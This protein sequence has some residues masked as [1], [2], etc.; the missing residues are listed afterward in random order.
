MGCLKQNFYLFENFKA[1]FL[2]VLFSYILKH[3]ATLIK[4]LLFKRSLW[5]L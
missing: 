1:F 3:L 2:I 5:H 4:K